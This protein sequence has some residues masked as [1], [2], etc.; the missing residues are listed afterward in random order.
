[1]GKT[2]QAPLDDDYSSPLLAQYFKVKTS[3]MN[4]SFYPL[5]SLSDSNLFST[6]V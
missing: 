1:M 4:K 3:K 5:F 2:K 6:D